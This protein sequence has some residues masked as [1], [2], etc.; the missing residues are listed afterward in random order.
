M[1]PHSTTSPAPAG[2]HNEPR[3]RAWNAPSL[4]LTSVSNRTHT[5]VLT[6]ELT[7]RSASALEVEIE[8][9][10]EEGV[11]VIALDLRE[12]T[13]IDPTGV[14]VISFRRGYC[15]RQGCCLTLIAGAGAVHRALERAGIADV[16]PAQQDDVAARRLPA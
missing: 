8:R 15:E 14:A 11:A 5:L 10:C 4:K 6:G 7:H 2:R 9:L 3:R 1:E 12:L 16:L 13:S